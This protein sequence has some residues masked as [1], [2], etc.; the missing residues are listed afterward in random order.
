MFSHFISYTKYVIKRY[1]KK[2]Y[3]LNGIDK[4]ILPYIKKY[5]GYY[6]EI[7]ANDGITQ[8]NTYLLELKYNWTGLLIEPV[9]NKFLECLKNRSNKNYFE[10]A[11]C[12]SFTHDAEHI[13][14]IYSNLMTT[15]DHKL[16]LIESPLQHAKLGERF[17]KDENINILRVPAKPMN[18]VLISHN[19]PC[20]VDFLSLDVEGFE[21][22]V[23]NGIDHNKYRFSYILI[24]TRDIGKLRKI[25]DKISYKEIAK[26]THH[27]Y[28]FKNLK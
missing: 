10:N 9:P 27:D 5:S 11:A 28:L 26:I 13:D 20:L 16:N 23:L 24:E 4:K 15:A 14:L 7:G 22:E 8:S 17:L 21:N 12:V 6:V 2:S 3:G 25:M 18:D 19:A 1:L